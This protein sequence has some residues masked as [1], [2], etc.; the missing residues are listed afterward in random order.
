MQARAVAATAV[1][2]VIRDGQ[3]LTAALAACAPRAALADRPLVQELA[4]G[5]LRWYPRLQAISSLLLQRPLRTKDADIAALL[6]VGLYQLI[7]TRIPPHAAVAETVDAAQALGKGWARGLLNACL[8]R[9][10]REQTALLAMADR[11]PVAALAH[12][13]WLLGK[14]RK[15][16]PDDWQAIAAANNARP[17]MTLRVN[18]RRSSRAAWL[19]RACAEGLEAAPHPAAPA[20]VTLAQPVDVAR[21][22]GFATGDVS[23]QDAAAQFAAVLLDPGPGDRVLDACAAPGGKTLHLL[24]HQPDMVLVALDSDPARLTRIT[25][26]LDRAGCTAVLV[27]G[28]AAHPDAWWDG[29]RFDRILVD[30]PCSATGVIRRHPDI[31]T[32]RRAD[33][34]APL[35]ATQGAIL[36]ALWPLLAPGGRLLYATCSILPEENERQIRRF[37][38]AH[39]D[40]R[41]EPI[42][43]E[44]GRPRAH[45]RQI[46]P[47]EL[48]MDGF[49]YACIKRDA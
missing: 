16:W 19:E 18:L 31:K 34:L 1:C 44:W 38:A 42:E 3:S 29:T 17:P 37:L 5:T 43:G 25:E 41:E 30:A 49:Y 22:P 27:T 7:D 10:Q 35:A 45:G 24:E 46:L 36:D 2:R 14:L 39:P 23:V 40:A 11:D 26:N 33:D 21:L 4:Y 15:A 12:P 28:D 47:G 32:L 6:A 20:G 48:G 13:A 9:F 8:R